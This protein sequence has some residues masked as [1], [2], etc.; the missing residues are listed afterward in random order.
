MHLYRPKH[1]YVL[2]DALGFAATKRILGN[3]KDVPYSI[4]DSRADIEAH[5]KNQKDPIGQGKQYLLLARDKG[6]SFKPFPESPEYYSCDYHTLHLAE[7]CDLECSYC[8][9]QSYLTNPLLTV[10]VNIE[11][12]LENLQK[13]LDDYPDRFFRIGTGQIADSLSLDRITEYSKILVPFFALQHNAVLELKTKSTRIENLLELNPEGKTIA[14]WSLNS[15]KIQREEEHKCASILE[16]ISAAKTLITHADYRLAFHF[17]PLIDYPGWENEYAEV[18]NFLFAEIPA[19]RMA[20]ISLG[21]LRFMPD[22]KGIM[23]ERFPKSPLAS[24]EWITGM[25]GKMRYLKA[26]RV[27]VYQT[28]VEM[29]RSQS[30][31]VSLYLTME[32]PEVWR[33]VFDR[34]FS[35]AEI[36]GMLD[37]S[38][39]QR[40]DSR[41]FKKSG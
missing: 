13:I 14:A 33:K 20:W 6:R 30:K 35:K 3:L 31:D 16:R 34:E 29:V 41:C 12:M 39:K 22:L 10:H 11:E 17:D 38:V 27:E 26:R 40:I 25:D 2:R 15:E 19:E 8:I 37:E 23:Q 21:C 32:S 36:C 28:M 7:G 1:I 18:I 5:I 24:G 4:I 9:L